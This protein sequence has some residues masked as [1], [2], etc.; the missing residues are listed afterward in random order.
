[1]IGTF[2]PTSVPKQEYF[3][4]EPQVE[5]IFVNDGKTLEQLKGLL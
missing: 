3:Q 2:E 1:M 4:L 5:V